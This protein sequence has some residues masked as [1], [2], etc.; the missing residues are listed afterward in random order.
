M[1]L[2]V[3][4][5]GGPVPSGLGRMVRSASHSRRRE[6]RHPSFNEVHRPSPGQAVEKLSCAHHFCRRGW[7]SRP[8]ALAR[9]PRVCYPLLS[10]FCTFFNYEMIFKGRGQA[11]AGTTR[12]VPSIMLIQ[13][14]CAGSHTV[15]TPPPTNPGGHLDHQTHG[16]AD[17]GH[18]HA[19][20]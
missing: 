3:A 1:K 11:K 4:N 6:G 14:Q 19:T 5:E 7:R 13:P 8:P 17:F 18:V 10:K 16:Q 2:G 20:K 15:T 12:R 9:K